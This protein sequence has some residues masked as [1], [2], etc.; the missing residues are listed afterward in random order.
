[1]GSGV[2]RCPAGLLRGAG[3][4]APAAVMAF[5]AS[6]DFTVLDLTRAAFDLSDRGVGG[7]P[8]PGANDLFF[9]T[10]RGVYRPG[11]TV[12]LTGLLRDDAGRAI[13]NLPL[14][15]RLMRPDAVQAREL[16]VTTGDARRPTAHLPL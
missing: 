1:G 11:E 14:T 7:R 10:D 15:L 9:Y 5:A 12:H 4:K 3:G 8:A 16:V 2:G 13:D 6:G